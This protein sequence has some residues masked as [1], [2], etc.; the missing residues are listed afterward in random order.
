MK[1]NGT[2]L[3]HPTLQ[4]QATPC[5]RLYEFVKEVSK[6]RVIMPMSLSGRA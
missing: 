4:T 1:E 3:D 6:P 2:I 5:L